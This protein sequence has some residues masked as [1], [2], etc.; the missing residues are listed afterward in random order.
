MR[1]AG[2]SRSNA[3]QGFIGDGGD[4]SRL[5]TALPRLDAPAVSGTVQPVPVSIGG[6]TPRK[7]RRVAII[8][9]PAAPLIYAGAGVA[10]A[11]TES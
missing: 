4:F 1:R 2:A 10:P 5:D 6:A 3:G 9:F 8:A 7:D 11:R